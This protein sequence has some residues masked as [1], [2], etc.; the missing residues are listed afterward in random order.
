MRYGTYNVSS[1]YRAGS[2]TAA[3]RELAR[4]ELDLV[5]VQEARWDKRGTI[6][7]GII[8][9]SLEK[10]TKIINWEQDCF[11]FVQYPTK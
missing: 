8:I 2:L 10:E 1:F 9:F 11:F 4:Y 5:G 3:S 7:A 6:R